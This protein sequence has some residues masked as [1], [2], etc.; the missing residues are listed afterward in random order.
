MRRSEHRDEASV[1]KT[2]PFWHN[3]NMHTRTPLSVGLIYL[4]LKE[5]LKTQTCLSKCWEKYHGIITRLT[6]GI[7]V[8]PLYIYYVFDPLK[9]IVL[10]LRKS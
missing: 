1:W 10:D 7:V 4:N 3:T 5:M 2:G 8:I 9:M 6:G